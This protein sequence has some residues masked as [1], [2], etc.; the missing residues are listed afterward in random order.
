[1][2]KLNNEQLSRVL[3]EHAAGTLSY[4]GSWLVECHACVAEAALIDSVADACDRPKYYGSRGFTEAPFW[5]LSNAT[6]GGGAGNPAI[7]DARTP[8]HLLATLADVG[9]A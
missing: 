3:S 2:K 5:R 8:E 4:Y 1:M 7:Y 6:R 9:L